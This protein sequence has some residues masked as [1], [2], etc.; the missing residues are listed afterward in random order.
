MVCSGVLLC[1]AGGECRLRLLIASTPH[2]ARRHRRDASDESR[3]WRPHRD[4]AHRQS[5]MSRQSRRSKDDE[6]YSSD[7]DTVAAA[8]RDMEASDSDEDGARKHMS[9]EERKK[10]AKEVRDSASVSELQVRVDGVFMIIRAC[11][12]SVGPR[13]PSASRSCAR[14]GSCPYLQL[15]D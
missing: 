10:R 1:F 2:A 5:R 12:D 8:N 9:E 4:T 15:T 3:R 6:E 11:R 13:R 14:S 7:E